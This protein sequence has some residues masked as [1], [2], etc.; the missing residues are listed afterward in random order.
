M[1]MN[2]DSKMLN[3]TVE[4]NMKNSKKNNTNVDVKQRTKTYSNRSYISKITS[5]PLKGGH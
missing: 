4:Y 2:N 1:N 3:R 5:L